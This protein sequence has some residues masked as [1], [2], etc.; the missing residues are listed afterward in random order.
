M[1]GEIPSEISQ[2]AKDVSKD[3]FETFMIRVQDLYW[4]DK[5]LIKRILYII[6]FRV[7]HNSTYEIFQKNINGFLHPEKKEKEKEV[8][9][10]HGSGNGKAL[11]PEEM[12]E[13]EEVEDAPPPPVKSNTGGGGGGGG[14][15]AGSAGPS[16]GSS[17]RYA[18][19]CRADL[20]RV[21][22]KRPPALRTVFDD[23][24]TR[25]QQEY[26]EEQKVCLFVFFCLF[27]CVGFWFLFFILYFVFCILHVLI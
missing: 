2:S 19:E 7:T 5:K 4:D 14:G 3:V 27:V 16:G 15:A 17:E 20:H 9:K 12:E 25:Q 24:L 8:V 6:N 11:K 22:A 18:E 13:G 10:E 23:L 1:S 26:A 21:K